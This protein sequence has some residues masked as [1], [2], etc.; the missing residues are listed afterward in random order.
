MNI[1]LPILESPEASAGIEAGD[2]LSLD[3][4]TGSI[5]NETKGARYTAAAFPPFMR[6]IM[7]A[8]GL[9]GYVAT[10]LAGRGADLA[11]V[12]ANAE[13]WKLCETL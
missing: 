2:R 10:E 5:V 13:S 7:E 6:K 9:S 1:G 3:F 11:R 8:G 12:N 4:D